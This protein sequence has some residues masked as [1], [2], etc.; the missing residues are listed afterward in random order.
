MSTCQCLKRRTWP[1][2]HHADWAAELSSLGSSISF[3][4]PLQW[5]REVPRH[6]Y[7]GNVFGTPSNAFNVTSQHF[8]LLF[9]WRMYLLCWINEILK[10]FYWMPKRGV[11]R[12][13]FCH[14]VS[15]EMLEP[16]VEQPNRYG[17]IIGQVLRF[18]HREYRQIVKW[19]SSTE[20]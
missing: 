13:S 10:S 11:A 19:S 14:V 5:F 8:Y 1:I 17:D 12:P 7:H 15:P 9:T 20:W 4:A 16:R 3:L 6:R 2:Y 18:K